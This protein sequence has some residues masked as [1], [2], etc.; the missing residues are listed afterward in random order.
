M[1]KPLIAVTMGDP[2]EVGPEVCL[3]LLANTSVHEFVTPVIF[4][5]ARL[6]ANCAWQTGL[7]APPSI[8]KS[9]ESKQDTM[10]VQE[11]N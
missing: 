9:A 10:E 2:A 3:Q 5:D 11:V 1:S 4:G 7:P 6:L 8:S